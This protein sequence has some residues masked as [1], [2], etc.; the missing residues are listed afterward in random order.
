MIP[1]KE[2]TSEKHKIA[3]RMP[4]NVRMFKGEMNHED[5][6]LHL[7]QQLHIFQ[8]M[9]ETGLPHE[10]LAR[11]KRVQMDIDELSAK[12]VPSKPVL[13]STQ[14]YANYLKSLSYEELLP[15]IYLNYLAIMFGGQI[16]KKSVPSS[17]NMYDFNN[18]K[19][20]M[21]AVRQVQKD[22]WA[23]EVNKGFDFTIDIFEELEA[24]S[25]KLKPA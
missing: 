24:E 25:T 15:H 3:E 2:A 14:E 9:E 21:M 16:M 7:V 17:G 23:D 18:M 12:G 8:T 11:A 1:L 19:E 13:N 10:D 6:L 4:F 5:Y 20:A 22:E